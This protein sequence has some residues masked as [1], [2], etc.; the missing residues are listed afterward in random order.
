MK[1]KFYHEPLRISSFI[2]T[3]KTTRLSKSTLFK[4]V[5]FPD[6]VNAIQLSDVV[7]L[8]RLVVRQAHISFNSPSISNTSGENS[9]NNNSNE[10]EIDT[11]GVHSHSRT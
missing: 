9:V 3:K 1:S 6:A 10:R 4:K 11:E 5:V 7:N 2:E 8:R